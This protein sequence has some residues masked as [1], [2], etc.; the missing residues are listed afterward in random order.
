MVL[1]LEHDE[2]DAANRRLLVVVKLPRHDGI[3]EYAKGSTAN[4]R[5]TIALPEA[6]AQSSSCCTKLPTGHC[7][8]RFN[9]RRARGLGKI[10]STANTSK[11]LKQGGSHKQGGLDSNTSCM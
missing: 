7:N 5:R 10:A 4:A 6:L 9:L 3:G 1:H 8:N 2:E 11:R